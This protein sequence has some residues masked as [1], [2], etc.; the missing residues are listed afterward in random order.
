MLYL[1]R[2][3]ILGDLFYTLLGFLCNFHHNTVKIN[4]NIVVCIA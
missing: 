3:L 1:G 4:K 2:L